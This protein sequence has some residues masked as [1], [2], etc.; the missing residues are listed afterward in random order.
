MRKKC[1]FLAMLLLGFQLAFIQPSWPTQLNEHNNLLADALKDLQWTVIEKIEYDADTTATAFADAQN[2]D[3][4]LSLKDIFR[5]PLVIIEEAINTIGSLANAGRLAEN[6]QQLFDSSETNL[7]MVSA[8][9]S[10]STLKQVGENL[11]LAIDGP[12][13]CSSI[14]KM[15]DKAYSRSST[16]LFFNY[17][18]YRNTIKDYLY[19]QYEPGPLRIPHKSTDFTRRNLEIASGTYKIQHS[20]RERFRAL[21]DKLEDN[22]LSLASALQAI[23]QIEKIKRAIVASKGSYQ[24]LSYETYLKDGTGTYIPTGITD[25]ELGVIAQSEKMRRI[26]FANLDRELMIE[27]I[28]TISR[29]ARATVGATTLYIHTTYKSPKTGEVLGKVQKWSLVPSMIEVGIS[30]IFDT[31]AREQVNMIPQEMMMDLP[32]E[33]SNVWMVADDTASYIEYLI[34]T[35]KQPPEEVSKGIPAEI[36]LKDKTIIKG[37]IQQEKIKIKTKY[38]EMDIPVENFISIIGELIKLKDGTTLKGNLAEKILSVKTDYGEFKVETKEIDSII[39]VPAVPKLSALDVVKEYIKAGRNADLKKLAMLGCKLEGPYLTYDDVKNWDLH[40]FNYIKEVIREKESEI[41]PDLKLVV[42]RKEKGEQKTFRTCLVFK[43]PKG[44]KIYVSLKGYGAYGFFFDYPTSK[45]ENM[46]RAAWFYA[47]NKTDL[48]KAIALTQKAVESNPDDAEAKYILGYVYAQ[49]GDYERAMSQ[50]KGAMIPILKDAY[51]SL[52]MPSGWDAFSFALSG[53]GLTKGNAA[54]ALA[55]LGDTSGVPFLKETLGDDYLECR[56]RAALALAALGDRSGIPTLKRWLEPENIYEATTMDATLE[57]TDAA[58]ALA[59]LGDKSGTLFLKRQLTSGKQDRDRIDAAVALAKLGDKSGIPILEKVLGGV[60][61]NID[62][63]ETA[64]SLLKL[65]DESGIS[66]LHKALENISSA[67]YWGNLAQ[68]MEAAVVLARWGDKTV[69]PRLKKL[70]NH[71]DFNTRAY[72]ALAL[73]D[74]LLDDPELAYQIEKYKENQAERYH[75]QAVSYFEKGQYEEA[76]G[77]YQK[78]LKIS[79]DRVDIHEW[80]AELYFLTGK[81]DSAARA[82]W[83]VIFDQEGMKRPKVTQAQKSL[84]DKYR[85]LASLYDGIMWVLQLDLDRTELPA[86]ISAK[87]AITQNINSIKNRLKA[88]GEPNAENIFIYREGETRIRIQSIGG[89]RNLQ[90]LMDLILRT[91]RLEFKLVDMKGDVNKALQGDI[92]QDDQILYDS[93]KR[94]YLLKKETLLSGSAIKD[95]RVEIGQWGQP[96]ISLEFKS[97]AIDKWAEITGQHVEERIAI[98]L[99]NV[100]KSAPVVK[101]RILQGKCVIEGNFTIEQAQDLA[102]IIKSG[103]LAAPLNII[104]NTVWGGDAASSFSHG[105]VVRVKFADPIPRSSTGFRDLR[106]A[107]SSKGMKRCMVQR[108][109]K[110]SDNLYMIWVDFPGITAETMHEIEEEAKT[111]AT[112]LTKG[113]DTKETIESLKQWI[114]RRIIAARVQEA[115]FKGRS[116]IVQSIDTIEQI[117]GGLE[118]KI[119]EPSVKKKQKEETKVKSEVALEEASLFSSPE[120]TVKTYIE[121]IVDGNLDLICSSLSETKRKFFPKTEEQKKDYKKGLEKAAKMFQNWKMMESKVTDDSYSLIRVEVSGESIWFL[122]RKKNKKWEIIGSSLSGKEQLASDYRQLYYIDYGVPEPLGKLL[123]SLKH[124][125][126]GLSYQNQGKYDE[127]IQE[128][129]RVLDIW[130]D[131][132]RMRQRLAECYRSKGMFDKAIAELKKVLEDSPACFGIRSD[133][134]HAYMDK[135]MYEEAIVEFKKVIEDAPD[136]LP[137]S[138]D[139]YYY[140]ALC[141]Y[142]KNLY[143]EATAA[144]KKYLSL[145]LS[146]SLRKQ[147]TELLKKIKAEKQQKTLKT[148]EKAQQNAKKEEPKIPHVMARVSNADDKAVMYVNGQEAISVSWGTGAGGKS[149]GHRSGDSGWIDITPYLKTGDNTFRFWVWNKAVYGAVSATFEVQVDGV[150]T[151]SRNFKREDSSEGVKYDET[152]TLSLPKPR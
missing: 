78:A 14:E 84:F 82:M 27:Q 148:D 8:I 96:Y 93:K 145:S 125:H 25:L 113:P 24:K 77:E 21:R 20:I 89:L 55:K 71:D 52:P 11:Q 47:S 120:R 117:K 15:L 100:V 139:I 2:I 17:D 23:N 42:V 85:K 67:I 46:K 28:T 105:L 50:Y 135:K 53:G 48:D 81:Y 103:S 114:L 131:D 104:Q 138:S 109:G 4:D 74:L 34:E 98:I 118:R 59:K 12:S 37:E 49:K 99:D 123:P 128:Y 57:K 108:Y 152:V 56:I 75:K 136:D 45:T 60:Y 22:P 76:I 140:L 141:C 126:K 133:L 61:K 7:Q 39:F 3:R 147:V 86:R 79:P 40:Y 62:P 111:A 97:E 143:D 129:K 1:L 30:K 110:A 33:L 65:G 51:E 92:P 26:A 73:T 5:T 149:I 35:Q 102:I 38:G 44:Y 132:I 31:N 64:T 16:R 36:K 95:A 6:A 106:E 150:P 41:D 116:G 94:P 29:A 19:A 142:H 83:E 146:V 127:A 130:S 119:E 72:V 32:L 122:L 70:L 18:A 137:K 134:A 121:A 90:R 58:V 68:Y 69:I 66:I 43:T 151:I 13:Y 54:V 9:M 107:L 144:A 10:I 112:E 63:T 124:Y 101:S 80:L 87:E 115:I 91:G 88:C